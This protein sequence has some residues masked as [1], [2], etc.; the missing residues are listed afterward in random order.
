MKKIITLASLIIV[1]FSCKAQ[2]I[3]SLEK[4]IEYR[5]ADTQIPDGTYLKD[6]NNLLDNIPAHGKEFMT[7]KILYV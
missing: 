5:D 6:V 1:T 4:M 2:Q 3:V 7:A